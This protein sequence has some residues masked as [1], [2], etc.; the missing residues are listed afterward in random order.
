MDRKTGYEVACSMRGC[1]L[2]NYPMWYLDPAPAEMLAYAH[3]QRWKDDPET[4]NHTV[5][6]KDLNHVQTSNNPATGGMGVQRG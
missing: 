6:V 4:F 1:Y 2:N 5:V 3:E